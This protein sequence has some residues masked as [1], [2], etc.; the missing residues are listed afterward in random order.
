M[1]VPNAPTD[2]ALSEYGDGTMTLTWVAP[3]IDGGTEITGYNVYRSTPDEASYAQIVTGTTVL[4]LVQIGLTNGVD[5]Y[6]EVTA[7]N[8]DGEGARSESVFG[9]PYTSPDAPTGVV[10]TSG[11]ASISLVWVAPVDT[12]GRPIN[13]YRVNV[14]GY[15][16]SYPISSS[17]EIVS[18]I[19]GTEIIPL[20]NGGEYSI[21]VAASN[22]AGFG[23]QSAPIISWAYT[24]PDAPVGVAIV[25]GNQFLDFSWEAPAYNGGSEILYYK[26]YVDNAPSSDVYPPMMGLTFAGLTNGTTY[27]LKVAAFNE[28]GLSITS[29]TIAGIPRTVPGAPTGLTL[30]PGN[31]RMTLSW[32]A[33]AST[34]GAAIDYYQVIK[35]G[36]PLA[37]L[38]FTTGTIVTGL[39]NHTA[40]TFTIKAHNEAGL[41][42]ASTGATDMPYDDNSITTAE[43]VN[44]KAYNLDTINGF[45]FD[46]TTGTYVAGGVDLEL[47][48]GYKAVSGIAVLSGTPIV[49]AV[50]PT[51]VIYDGTATLKLYN[52]SYAEAVGHPVYVNAM[53]FAKKG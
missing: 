41:S 23:A 11:D 37:K 8:A 7:V 10:A 40:Y 22:D 48:E 2:L 21:T 3:L 18:Y 9:A 28:A 6:Y 27:V 5:Y 42:A 32:T 17:T 31:A 49:E 26:T 36:T 16:A 29:S 24:V 52:A 39:T 13:G 30:V 38:A 34:G 33:P 15:V 19:N 35:N 20:V 43:P 50:I 51:I 1:A 25:E 45:M 4:T 14:D 46:I 44:G 47:P 53:V 12:G